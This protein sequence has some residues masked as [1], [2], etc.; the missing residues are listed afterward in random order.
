MLDIAVQ[1]SR[2]CITHARLLDDVQALLDLLCVLI[3]IFAADHDF[4]RHLAILQLL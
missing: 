2:M 1:A 3:G 4:E